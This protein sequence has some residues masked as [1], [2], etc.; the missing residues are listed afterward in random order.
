MTL[1]P[2]RAPPGP[3]SAGPG[4]GST[5]PS[6]KTPSSSRPLLRWA[7]T[8]SSRMDKD[9]QLPPDAKGPWHSA[10]WLR[11]ALPA[12]LKTVP[13][14]FADRPA[15]H[16]LAASTLRDGKLQKKLAKEAAVRKS[17]EDAL[18]SLN[19]LASVDLIG[20]SPSESVDSAPQV[21]SGTHSLEAEDTT[22][23]PGEN[24]RYQDD[25]EANIARDDS[26]HQLDGPGPSTP[27]HGAT[28]HG[29][30][31]PTGTPSRALTPASGH[32]SLWEFNTDNAETGQPPAK[33]GRSESQS[34]DF[35]PRVPHASHLLRAIATD[36]CHTANLNG[37]QT[38][39]ALTFCDL[40]IAEML[41]DIKI[42][43]LK[44][45]NDIL[46]RYFR[47][48]HRH[49]D[50]TARTLNTNHLTAVADPRAVQARLRGLLAAVLFAHNT[51]A[52]L[53]N[54]T[55][56]IAEYIE[57]HLDVVALTPQCRDDPV[58]WGLVKS[59]IANEIS[60]LR[61]ALKSKL[62]ASVKNQED[63]YVLTTTALN[64]DIRP[65]E[66]HWARFAFLRHCAVE[67]KNL[68]NTVTAKQFWPF[69]DNK[70]AEV[71]KKLKEV[72]ADRRKE[73]ETKF[74]ADLLRVDIQLYPIKSGAVEQQAY[75]N[76]KLRSIQVAM[77]SAVAG[78]VVHTGVEA[79]AE[80]AD[81]Q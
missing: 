76:A 25:E 13:T 60:Q 75:T 10:L 47:L 34:E 15:L 67:F 41:V 79:A 18:R 69:V 9:L 20:L 66:Q 49:P 77:E 51:P 27:L 39:D 19:V 21:P 28:T 55:N 32:D 56:S 58:D 65:K 57:K 46:A 64:H 14:F 26:H 54:I 6:S 68:G 62:D 43:L 59:A 29:V 70:L 61:S 16:R 63:I 37:E 2:L 24:T 40:T 17:A 35:G 1:P 72:Q 12:H 30:E 31:T 48:Y 52:Y 50:F 71:R 44:N 22:E 7:D 5:N 53:N 42:H 73:S 45:E 74:F 38:N 3:A 8:L 33:H 4:A 23:E 11:K 81:E 80:E 78:F 36:K